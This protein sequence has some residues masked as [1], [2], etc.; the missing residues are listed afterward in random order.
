VPKGG[1][2]SALQM[3]RLSMDDMNQDG[4]MPEEKKE[5]E[6]MENGG[7]MPAAPAE[8]GAEETPAA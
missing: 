5:E 8:E 4:V 1:Q 2:I 7:E 6:G 3:R